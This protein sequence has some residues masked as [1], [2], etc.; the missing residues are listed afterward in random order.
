M[1]GVQFALTR[2]AVIELI[3]TVSVSMMFNL[4]D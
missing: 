4:I 2:S 3:L 1:K